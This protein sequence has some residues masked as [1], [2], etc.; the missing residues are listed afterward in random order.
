V[1]YRLY[2]LHYILCFFR[3]SFVNGFI[4]QVAPWFKLGMQEDSHEFLRILIDAM[5]KSC[6]KAREQ[7][8][9]PEPEEGTDTPATAPKTDNDKEYPFYLF[10]GKIESNVICD[11]CGAS[12]STFDPIEDI[13]LEVTATP[14]AAA[15]QSTSRSAASSRNNSPT[16]HTLADVQ[17]AFQ[18]FAC[19]EAL[20]AAYKCETC[21]KLGKA[22][23]QSR[24]ASIPPILTLHLKRFRYGDS[25]AMA[26]AA[27]SS[28]RTGRSEVNQLLGSNPDFWTGKSGSA[29]IEGHIKF[30]ECFDIKP[31]L[32]DE[33]QKEHK[34]M[35]CR[36]FAVVVHAGKNSH[37][38]HYIA[39]VRNMEKNEWWKMDDGRVSQSSTVEVLQAEAY[40]LF[41][42]VVGHPVTVELEA[43]KSSLVKNDEK[44]EQQPP[45][46]QQGQLLSVKAAATTATIDDVAAATIAAAAAIESNN[47]KRKREDFRNG[48]DWAKAKTRVPPNLLNILR[49]AEEMV[50]DN[51]NLSGDYFGLLSKAANEGKQ[52]LGHKI[53]GAFLSFCDAKS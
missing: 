42:R 16:P 45:Q 26:S 11:L 48:Q 43:R 36:L 21:G 18:R 6:E 2:A 39:Y 25:R 1:V 8:V 33:L 31:Y 34:S 29:K 27:T 35:F 19:A 12:S 14:N 24:L 46:Q 4:E 13:G 51:V 41:Y 15:E 44:P 17:S 49:K 9:K 30:A 38:G 5:Q 3:N 7:Q 50:A 20:D 23:K 28:R 52:K 47:H 10:R 22:T 40:M 32:T 37:S 53:S